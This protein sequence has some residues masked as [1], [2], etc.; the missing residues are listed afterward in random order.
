M[1]GPI[2]RTFFPFLGQTILHIRHRH[3]L[4]FIVHTQQMS[5]F[6]CLMLV[7]WFFPVVG[8]NGLCYDTKPGLSSIVTLAL[9]SK[10]AI[11]YYFISL[12]LWKA[13]PVT[14]CSKAYRLMDYVFSHQ[15]KYNGSLNYPL[16]PETSISNK[17]LWNYFFCSNCAL[18]P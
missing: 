12:S 2:F 9:V 13:L 15:I 16:I 3:S 4:V 1:L 7:Q 8:T 17:T 10:F 14:M 11:N 5:T 6:L 18:I